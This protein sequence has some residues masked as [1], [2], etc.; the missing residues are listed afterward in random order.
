[1][2]DTFRDLCGELLKAYEWCI[3]KYMTAPA[4]EDALVQRAR[5]AL[6]EG[7]G[8]GPTN[9]ELIELSLDTKL[10][11]FQPTAGDP[12]VYELSDQQLM[13]YARAV[14]ARWGNKA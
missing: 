3:D 8:V 9:E 13:A 14:L 2:T 10:Y 6:A 4:S 1:M 5:T 12:I 7:A 11:R